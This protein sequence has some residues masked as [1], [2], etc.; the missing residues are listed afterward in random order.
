GYKIDYYKFMRLQLAMEN[1]MIRMLEDMAVLAD[2]EKYMRGSNAIQCK[3]IDAVNSYIM[4]KHIETAIPA[5]ESAVSNF[6][7][8]ENAYFFEMYNIDYKSGS[9]IEEEHLSEVEK[10]LTLLKGEISTFL[11]NMNS[12][13]KSVDHIIGLE[14]TDVGDFEDG[15]DSLKKISEKLREDFET[16]EKSK[17]MEAKGIQ[18][19]IDASVATVEGCM[20]GIDTMQG[21]VPETNAEL[22][23]PEYIKRASAFYDVYQYTDERYQ[24]VLDNKA[25][26]TKLYYKYMESERL[27][28]YFNN[29]LFATA[30]M[31]LPFGNKIKGAKLALHEGVTI[32]SFAYSA[33][34]TYKGYELMQQV[35]AMDA[36]SEANGL[37]NLENNEYGEYV[38]ALGETCNLY[39]AASASNILEYKVFGK[40]VTIS[41]NIAT[42]GE[43]YISDKTNNLIYQITGEQNLITS[44]ISGMVG[45]GFVNGVKLEI[46]DAGRLDIDPSVDYDVDF[47]NNSV[48]MDVDA[49]DV[50]AKDVPVKSV[51]EGGNTSRPTWR[52]SELDAA[53]DFPDYDAQK[54]FING[55][56]VP[57]GTKGSVRPDYYKN[58]Y[59]VDVKNYNV[60]SASGRSNLARNIEKQ[61]YQ[62][63][64]NLPAGTKQTVMIDIRGQSI[65]DASMSALYDDIMRRTNNGVEILFKMD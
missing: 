42:C 61:Y 10:K 26:Q 38:I 63:I 15:L 23:V 52:Q 57:Y 48:I 33:D 29:M 40:P 11:Q 17:L 35:E 30:S 64:Q 51:G 13:I 28:Q 6:Y 37:F 12:E 24:D 62:R 54:S 39:T 50:D 14:S 18:W 27:S 22:E 1:L 20:G 36:D 43:E 59:S 5:I 47:Q 46:E 45:N 25:D 32:I 58:G 19:V 44:V 41:S 60:E 53:K 2:V 55:Q 65:S 21:Y 34:R 7:K 49:K 8:V 9:I 4:D 16:Y 3:S 31:V 56:E